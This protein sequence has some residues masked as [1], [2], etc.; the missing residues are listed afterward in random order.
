MR[1]ED[2]YQTIEQLWKDVESY[3][4]GE[5]PFRPRMLITRPREEAALHTALEEEAAPFLQD[6]FQSFYGWHVRQHPSGQVLARYRLLYGFLLQELLRLPEYQAIHAL[7]E[8][9]PEISLE[10]ARIFTE[11]LES[12]LAQ[13][14]DMERDWLILRLERLEAGFHR[15]AARLDRLLKLPGVPEGVLLRLGTRLHSLT[16]QEAHFRW[17][18]SCHLDLLRE[19]VREAARL[20]LERAEELYHVSSAWG[21]N[22]DS[23]SYASSNAILRRHLEENPV[24]LEISRYIGKLKE[25]LSKRRENT[26]RYGQGENY[27]ITYGRELSQLLPSESVLLARRETVPMFVERYLS[28]RL[29]QRQLR[30][31]TTMGKGAAI[32]C[33]DESGS[34]EGSKFV[35]AKSMAF[36]LLGIFSRQERPMALVHFADADECRTD[37]FLPGCYTLEEALD[38]AQHFFC[39][40]GTDFER[41]LRETIRLVEE[42]SLRDADILFLT[43]GECQVSDGFAQRFR[44]QKQTLGFHVTGVL[45]GDSEQETPFGITPFC[46]EI[47]TFQ[48]MSQDSVAAV[49][50]S[51]LCA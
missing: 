14:K 32:V 12:K 24:L 1:K 31:K 35:W 46:D 39:G 47:Y 26:V 48:A 37:L 45:M 42:Q 25:I 18:L 44:Q 5:S 30:E 38:S 3:L 6:V 28:G 43:D 8:G 9:Q 19:P 23:Q 27:D 16:E 15:R 7:C 13:D 51:R 34:M 33:L 21:L 4:P 17:E 2:A 20:A 50:L 49:I 22:P 11:S 29:Q 10:A 40:G 41:P 36:A